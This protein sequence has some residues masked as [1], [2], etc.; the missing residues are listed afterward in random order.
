[1]GF[2]KLFSKTR[3]A[4]QRLPSGSMTVDRE[5]NVVTTTVASTYPPGLLREIGSE[6]LRLFLEARKAQM[7]LSELNLDFAS[8]RI[9]AREMRGGAIVFLSPKTHFTTSSS[10][11]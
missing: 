3:P 2:L 6:V 9:T 10:N 1:M 4:L 7:P 8:L 5:G 11:R